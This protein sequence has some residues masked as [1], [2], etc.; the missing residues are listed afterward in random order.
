[1]GA[2]FTLSPPLSMIAFAGT[3]FPTFGFEVVGLAVVAY[4]VS[5]TLA[6]GTIGAG[7]STIFRFSERHGRA[8]GAVRVAVGISVVGV[9]VVMFTDAFALF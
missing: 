6:M 1:V 2:L 7:I 9:A 5:I 8:Y 3:L 4:A